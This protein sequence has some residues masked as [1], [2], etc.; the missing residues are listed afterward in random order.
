LPDFQRD[1]V[2]DDIHIRSLIASIS[3][4]YPIGAI[5]LLETGGNGIRLKPRLVQGVTV[6]DDTEPTSLIL[7]GQQRLTSLYLALGTVE[8]VQTRSE[9]G[10]DIQRYYY[11]D[12]AKCLDPTEDRIDAV[13]SVPPNRKL[14]VDFGREVVLDISTP[15]KEY[16]QRLLPLS[17]LYDENEYQDWRREHQ[18]R[19][20][21][22]RERYREFDQFE[23]EVVRAFT[24][25]KVPTIVLPRETPKEAVCQVFERVNTGGVTLTVFELVTAT[26]AA[27]G[28]NLRDD[29]QG[30]DEES[31]RKG[32]LHSVSPL[33]GVE[34][35]DFLTCVTL[36][37]SHAK[38]AD[39]PNA[40]ISCK[41]RD[42]LD[43]GLDEYRAHADAVQQGFIDAAHLLNR[44]RVFEAK[45]IPY[46][47]Q[48][49]PLAAACAALGT[50]VYED[51][52]QDKL[53]RWYWCGVFGELY[54]S[55]TESRY[56]FD[57]PDIVSWVDGGPEPRTV[58]EA[59]FAP[60]RLLGMQT[61]QSAAYKGIIALLIDE[62]SQDFVNG[63]P[64]EL[65]TYANMAIEIHHIFPKKHCE[66]QQYARRKWNSIVNKAPLTSHTNGA[67]G[68]HAPSKYLDGIE[69]KYK[70]CSARLDG[71]LRTH[72]IN[73]E[74]LR[75]DDFDWF[76]QD[77]ATRLLDL[78]GGAMGKTITGR[79]SD[80]V[81]Q[82]FGDRLIET[83]T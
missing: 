27:D 37:A 54:G 81:V 78:I 16:E 82:E 42:V 47:S 60:T 13:V 10:V 79:D 56:A 6:P 5:M 28:H 19:N 77:R 72:A 71:I 21:D 43:L 17:V 41:R 73:P 24:N 65:T 48:L 14:T 63:N 70:I 33:E 8:A 80:E 59:S 23:R 39:N 32:D 51:P 36:Y 76:I 4:A 2:W 61:R 20:L 83:V 34:A 57:V 75:E 15:E 25:Y 67:I 9:K 45:N 46:Q 31:G 64:I 11:L 3:L 69:R 38:R 55:A 1:W 29:W 30:E 68:G 18:Q 50:R 44:E 49:V 7:D 40:T 26:F 53:A 58:Q 74:L 66:D 35:T 22:D 52:V 62:G 12:I